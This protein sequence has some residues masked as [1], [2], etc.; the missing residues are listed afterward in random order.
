V[1]IVHQVLALPYGH[2]VFLA[3]LDRSFRAGRNAFGAEKASPQVHPETCLID[4][5]GI[6]GTGLGT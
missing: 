5:D 6:R 2:A 4:G 3:V 1:A